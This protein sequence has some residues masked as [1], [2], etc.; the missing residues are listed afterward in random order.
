ML[1]S[2][3]AVF[4]LLAFMLL[5]LF[6]RRVNLLDERTAS[7]LNKLV[8]R[9]FL[10]INIF[11]SVYSADIRS[12]FDLKVCLYVALT[13]ILSFLVISLTV[14]RAE[15][16]KTIAPVMV[17]GI[18]KANYNLLSIPIVSSFFGNELGMTAVLIFI[19]TPIVNTCS[20][21]AF[22]SARGGTASF[23][24]MLRKIILNPMVYSSVLGLLVNISGL[25]IPALI[26]SSVLSKLGAIA[27]PAAMLA[28]GSGFDFKAVRRHARRLGIVCL[29]KLIIL[30][31]ILTTGAALL[32][33]RGANLI[34]TLMYSGS[35]TAVNSYSTAVSMGG[36]EELAGEVVAVTSLLSVF[37]LFLFLT[38]LQA[39]GLV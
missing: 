24:K 15:K 26:M 9:V 7:G 38:A 22:E 6:L 34:A 13:C 30:P 32:G 28:L 2:F 31:A 20:T 17:Q 5:G 10:P 19:I 21:I 8:F 33:I 1:L 12:A 23:P 39:L 3:Q 14:G 18:H 36:N 37:T 29:G 27:T 16:D 25:R 4:P 35:P 11:Q